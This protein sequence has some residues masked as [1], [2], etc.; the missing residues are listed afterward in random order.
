MIT[1]RIIQIISKFTGSNYKKYIWKTY[2]QYCQITNVKWMRFYIN[3]LEKI[4]FKR[5]QMHFLCNVCHVEVAFL[6]P[7]TWN[8]RA[9][10]GQLP[11][12][13]THCFKCHTIPVFSLFFFFFLYN[14]LIIYI[15][16]VFPLYHGGK[17]SELN[18]SCPPWNVISEH[19]GCAE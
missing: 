11:S 14:I 8:T 9:L 18:L 10:R 5:K 15:F 3:I 2:F 17:F 12:L 4:H 1:I 13:H 19:Y 6:V 7:P 16:V